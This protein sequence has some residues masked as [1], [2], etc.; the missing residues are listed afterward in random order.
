MPVIALTLQGTTVTDSNY[1]HITCLNCASNQSTLN[2][3]S[4]NNSF[5]T[6]LYRS[7]VIFWL[8]FHR[9]LFS[10][11]SSSIFFVT[12]IPL[13]L[14]GIV[15]TSKWSLN[16]KY[17]QRSYWFAIQGRLISAHFRSNLRKAHFSNLTPDS[18]SCRLWKLFKTRSTLKRLFNVSRI[19][20]LQNNKI[21][22]AR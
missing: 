15:R 20:L 13:S 18:E 9:W 7:S 12:F 14:W 10:I 5:K 3:N 1:L 11:L 6:T 17:N 2:P 4:F 16:R 8:F 21:K 19:D 22:T